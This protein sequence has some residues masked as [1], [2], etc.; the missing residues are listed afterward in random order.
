[1]P[2]AY[3]LVPRYEQSGVW[4]RVYGEYLMFYRIGHVRIDVLHV[5]RGAR[6]YETILFPDH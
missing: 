2:R 5:L 4:R 6:D 3:S 1:M